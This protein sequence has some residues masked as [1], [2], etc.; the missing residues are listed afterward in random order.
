VNLNGPNCIVNNVVDARAEFNAR[1]LIAQVEQ[2]LEKYGDLEKYDVYCE[3][4]EDT[5]PNFDYEIW[6]RDRTDDSRIGPF[7]IKTLIRNDK[8]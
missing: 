5:G 3:W 7:D 1:A 4:F 2:R 6:L 8:I